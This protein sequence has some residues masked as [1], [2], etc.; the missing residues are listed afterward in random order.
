MPAK[1]RAS[2][3]ETEPTAAVWKYLRMHRE[4]LAP[5]GMQPPYESLRG[6]I[7]YVSFELGPPKDAN[8]IVVEV[9]GGAGNTYTNTTGVR[10]LVSFGL[11]WSDASHGYL[12]SPIGVTV[13]GIIALD[14]S[15]RFE[16]PKDLWMLLGFGSS[17]DA[18]R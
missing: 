5:S 14:P 16:R 17:T 7:R 12:V 3:G 15:G 1:L 4:A 8:N 6:R 18:E 2:L 10:K 11:A 13:N 9:I